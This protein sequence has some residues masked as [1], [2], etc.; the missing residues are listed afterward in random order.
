MKRTKFFFKDAYMQAV[1]QISDPKAKTELI[2]A[3]TEYGINGTVYQGETE[4]VKVAMALIMPQ[5]DKENRRYEIK[6]TA[7]DPAESLT[8]ENK[9]VDVPTADVQAS[10]QS[11]CGNATNNVKEDYSEMFRPKPR[12]RPITW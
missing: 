8:M 4:I 10:N 12:M 2:V 5:I 3:I 7:E 11:D 6:E 9:T 1:E